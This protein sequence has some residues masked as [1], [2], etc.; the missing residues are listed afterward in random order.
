MSHVFV[1]FWSL[2]WFTLLAHTGPGQ[3]LDGLPKSENCFIF[4]YGQ[5][6]FTKIVFRGF[7]DFAGSAVVHLAGAVLS[8]PGC[9]ILGAR[10]DTQIIFA[11]SLG[12]L[13]YPFCPG[14]IDGQRLG[15]SLATQSPL[16]A[17]DSSSLTLASS[18]STVA[19]R[20]P[21]AM[22][23]TGKHFRGLLSTRR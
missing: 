11:S 19:L 9:V 23:V 18:P 16:S 1:V 22:L 13:R 5:T 21:S 14:L 10:Y 15:E 17:S 4:F 3:D 12:I 2:G 20:A 8:L 7:T 6:L